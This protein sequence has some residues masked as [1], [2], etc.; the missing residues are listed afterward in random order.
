M[1]G[2]IIA[3]DK[4]KSY[5][6]VHNSELAQTYRAPLESFA[7]DP[8]LVVGSDCDFDDLAKP[9]FFS[10]GKAKLNSLSALNYNSDKVALTTDAHFE[11]HKTIAS[12]TSYLIGAEGG[13]ER[14]CRMALIEK[15]IECKSNCLLALKLEIVTRPGVKPVLFRYTGR[16][17]IIDGP[18]YKQEPGIGLAIPTNT[19]RR[20]SPNEAMVRYVRVLLL[21][22]LFIMVPVIMSLTQRGVIP[23]QQ[24]G[25]VA[26]ALLI[27]L[28]GFMFLF[29]FFKKRKTFILTLKSI[30]ES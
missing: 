18:K 28:C 8:A 7:N 22:L 5:C 9:S 15:A 23:S 4:A 27:G 13:S 3:V 30:R 14:E 12:N 1:Q 24:L 6:D 2:T 10:P 25:Q 29:V 26:T 21:S 19:A 16:P 11:G 17:A 20:N